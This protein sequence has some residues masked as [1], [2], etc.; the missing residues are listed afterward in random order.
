MT[1]QHSQWDLD[2]INRSIVAET[3]EVTWV[4]T[5]LVWLSLSEREAIRKNKSGGGWIRR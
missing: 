4:R 5:S 3:R 2:H 1:F